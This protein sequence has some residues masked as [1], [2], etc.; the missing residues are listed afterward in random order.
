MQNQT[1]LITGGSGGLG[2]AVVKLALDRGANLILPVTSKRSRNQVEASLNGNDRQRVQFY[3]TNLMDESEVIDLVKQIERIDGLVHLVGGFS[4]GE[5]VGYPQEKWQ[6]DFQLNTTTTFLIVKH[7]LKHMQQNGYGRIVTT[8]SGAATDPVGGL[9]GYSASKAA[10]V[11]FTQSVAK[12]TKGSDI[13]ANV[14][15]PSIIDT[16]ANRK[17]MGDQVAHKWVKPESLAEVILFLASDAARDIRGAAIPVL[18][19]V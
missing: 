16:P 15:L 4:M 13:T 10:V 19:N 5:T 9:P 7:V 18:G 11:S 12:E 2:Q 17:A 8:G 14:V 6:Q 1:I 3:Q